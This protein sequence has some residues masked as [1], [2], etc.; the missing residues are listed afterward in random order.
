MRSSDIQQAIYNQSMGLFQI[1]AIAIC[2]IISL[3]DGFDVLTIA[4]VAPSL[5]EQWQLMPEQLGLLFSAGLAG[6]I[7]GAL[8]IAPMADKF[9]RRFI[10]L[11][12]LTILTVGMLA[13]GFASNHIELVIA[14]I[15]TGV[16]MGAILPGINTVVAEYSSNRYRSLS[17]SVMAVGYTVG[18]LI[19]GVISIYL[20]NHFGWQYVFFFGGIFSCLMIPITWL[21]LPES[22]DFLLTKEQ[23][24]HNLAKLNYLLT[25][26]KLPICHEFPKEV[27]TGENPKNSFKLLC[28]PTVLK[29]TVL[30]A[31]SNFTLMCSLYFLMNWT[32]KILVDLGYSKD[33]SITGSLIMNIFGIA[34]GL[35]LGWLSRHYSVQKITALL[36]LM[37]FISVAAFG[38]SANILSL[39]FIIIGFIGFTVLGAMAGLYA[40]APTVFPPQIRATG[41]GLV[42]GLARFGATLGPYLAGLLIASHLPRAYYFLILGLP[43]LVCAS[44]IFIIKPYRK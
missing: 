16:G 10:I 9:G 20:I 5:A 22:L 37:G 14:R 33:L 44:C 35:A 34:G 28:T 26:L 12:C 6:M 11:S 8:F 23:N 1:I 38:L 2:V 15:F 25:K 43:L 39:L 19:G 18:A 42:L 36:S 21:N 3:I 7:I 4:F 41:T 27:A 32:P 31:I 24:R 40:T 13:S 29:T 30:L 17:I